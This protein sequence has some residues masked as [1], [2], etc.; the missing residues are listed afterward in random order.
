MLNISIDIYDNGYTVYSTHFIAYMIL[1]TQYFLPDILAIMIVGDH[2]YWFNMLFN[3][4]CCHSY[5]MNCCYQT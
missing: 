2:H 3:P 1:K 4:C 5:P